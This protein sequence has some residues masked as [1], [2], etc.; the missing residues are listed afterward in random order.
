[1][2][3]WAVAGDTYDAGNGVRI[4]RG[5]IVRYRE[6]YGASAP[7][8][9]LK[10]TA[11]EVARGIKAKEAGDTIAYGVL[12]PAAFAV[13]GGPSIAE[14]MMKEGVAFRRA[15]NK[16]VSQRGAMGGWDQMRARMKGGIDERPMM[17][18][19][20]TCR[21]FIRTVPALQHDADKPEDLDTSAE[22]HV[23]D[24][25]RYACMSRPWVPAQAEHEAPDRLDIQ[26]MPNGQ[27]LSNMSV[28]EIIEAKRKRKA[29]S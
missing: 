21:D 11:E 14:R 18:V 13:D 27:V 25:A 9:G 5:A 4:T 29:N 2:G 16:R 17:Y 15:D 6:W 1:V 10:L 26:V 20:D 12:D 28:Y 3:W 7:N 23:A 19:F 22:D 8:V 24:E